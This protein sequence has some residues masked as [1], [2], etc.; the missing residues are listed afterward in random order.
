MRRLL[1]APILALALA[2]G[3]CASL[4]I[5][6]PGGKSI[7]RGG[8]SIT[9][10]I[11]Q[12]IT[13]NEMV[14]I[15]STYQAGLIAVVNYRRFCYSKPLIQLPAFCANRRQVMTIA[16][17]AVGKARITMNSLRYF[18]ANNQTVN[19]IAAFNSAKQLIADLTT[20]VAAQGV[21]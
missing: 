17:A 19:A 9:A 8:T 10:S 1:L 4:D 14:A 7:L 2:L 21:P 20:A 15:E 12:P 3:G 16:Q 11:T 6:N 5:F 13:Q 18:V